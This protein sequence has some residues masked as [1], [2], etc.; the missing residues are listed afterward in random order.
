MPTRLRIQSAAAY[1]HIT[2]LG[3]DHQDIFLDDE[4]R[5]FYLELLETAIKEYAFEVAAW[6]LMRNHIHM[7]ARFEG[8][9]MDR[10]MFLIQGR[11]SKHFNK[12]HDRSGH[13]FERR[14]NNE[15]VTS[16]GYLHEAGRYI[17]QNPVVEGI[18]EQPEDY[19]WSSFHEYWEEKHVFVSKDSPLVTCFKPAGV[20]DRRAF[21]DFT[22]ARKRAAAD[23]EWYEKKAYA[24]FAPTSDPLQEAADRNHPIVKKVISEV[25][26]GFGYWGDIHDATHPS[27]ARD[28]SRALAFYLLKEV[29]PAW[30]TARLRAL[31]AI[32]DRKNVYRVLQ[33]CAIR[34]A[35]DP[36]F[37]RVADDVR[38]SLKAVKA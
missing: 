23:P 7:L 15:V 21:H 4:D 9:N 31:A 8:L 3:N 29:L 5:L 24:P 11:Y 20:F 33:K 37:R 14:Y 17:H 30:S 1:Q 12:R 38:A 18:V 19:R 36:G 35:R 6:C 34:L 32:N 25:C 10:A 26:R 28:N 13:L 22:T 2:A 27:R 16:V